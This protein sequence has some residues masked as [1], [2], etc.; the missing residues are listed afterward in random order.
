[1]IATR[2]GSIFPTD[3]TEFLTIQAPLKFANVRRLCDTVV[4]SRPLREIG[5][6]AGFLS[7]TYNARDVFSQCYFPAPTPNERNARKII[8]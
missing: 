1:M 5:C 8:E 4:W 2:Y 7:A 3:Y 6:Q